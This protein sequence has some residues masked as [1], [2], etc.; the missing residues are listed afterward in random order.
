MRVEEVQVETKTTAFVRVVEKRGPHG[1]AMGV[2]V[3]AVSGRGGWRRR[4]DRAESVVRVAG[5]GEEEVRKGEDE[6]KRPTVEAA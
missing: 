3:G 4:V 6:V 5:G 1:P 2:G